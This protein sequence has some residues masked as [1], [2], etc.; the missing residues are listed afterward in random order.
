[1]TKVLYWNIENFGIN[2][3]QIPVRAYKKKRQKG[4]SLDGANASQQR[5]TY[6]TRHVTETD[7]DIFV[8]VEVET[9]YNN[10]RGVLCTGAGAQ[11]LRTM[12]QQL[13][14]LPNTDWRLVPPLITGNKEAVGVFFRND[15]VTFTG[16]DQ[17]NG[18]QGPTVPGLT[19][20]NSQPYPAPWNTSLP[21]N[22]NSAARVQFT[23]T[24]NAQPA[25]NV[26][27]GD[28]VRHPYQ[29]NFTAGNRTIEIYSVH[30]P[31]N[32]AGATAFVQAL[33]TVADIAA[34]PGNNVLRLVL[35]DFNLSLLRV[36][37]STYTGCYAPLTG[38]ANNNYTVALI[39]AG[40]PPNPLWGYAGYFATHIRPRNNARVWSKVGDLAYYPAYFYSGDGNG[41]ANASIDNVLYVAGQNGLPGAAALTVVNGIV[42]SPYNNAG[43]NPGGAPQGTQAFNAQLD[44]SWNGQNPQ[45]QP[46]AG[47]NIAPNVAPQF[48][49]WKGVRGWFLGWNAYGV[50]RSTSDHLPLLFNG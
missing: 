47:N 30:A 20:Q 18:G 3:I 15:R 34:A 22:N 25:V 16:P 29:T 49:A 10:N 13:R 1:V 26:V 7:P 38:L 4:S 37:D 40:G 19:A 23:A 12:L 48:T 28:G 43:A 46:G 32:F 44:W 31:A 2:K 24:G 50:I 39:P 5:L 36:A 14:N 17:W 35:G 33:T 41:P 27:F 45:W 9:P 11:G 8:I 42:G 21:A 6:I